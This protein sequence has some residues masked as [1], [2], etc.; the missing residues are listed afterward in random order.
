MAARKRRADFPNDTR[1][2][3]V[4]MADRSSSRC[5]NPGAEKSTT[6]TTT[7]CGNRGEGQGGAPAVS[8]LP[9]NPEVATS[10]PRKNSCGSEEASRGQPINRSGAQAD[11]RGDLDRYHEKRDFEGRPNRAVR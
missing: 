4:K 1:G 6:I 7:L 3:R 10:T 2:G 9:R 11:K 8:T 5:R